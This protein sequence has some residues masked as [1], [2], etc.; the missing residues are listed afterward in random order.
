MYTGFDSQ[1][2]RR[3]DIKAISAK[4]K[5]WVIQSS[6]NQNLKFGNA[7]I[8]LGVPKVLSN[9]FEMTYGILAIL[10]HPGIKKSTYLSSS[11]SE[12]L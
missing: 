9:H 11:C 8:V 4:R 12:V 7:E 2:P 5:D 3:F 6:W 1:N 10:V